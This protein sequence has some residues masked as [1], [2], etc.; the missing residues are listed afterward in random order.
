MSDIQN[1]QSQQQHQS[2]HVHQELN[3]S[4]AML[5]DMKKWSIKECLKKK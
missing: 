3:R 4:D 1:G 5:K 2:N